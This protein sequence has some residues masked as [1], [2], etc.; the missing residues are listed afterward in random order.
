MG[1]T[2]FNPVQMHLL[3]MFSVDGSEERLEEV[4]QVLADF[5]AKKIERQ[6]DAL[7]DAGVLDQQRL[8]EIGKGHFRISP[9]DSSC[10]ASC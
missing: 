10:R 7:W 8:D 5:Y 6:F 2:V 1:N 9:K 3:H 4:R